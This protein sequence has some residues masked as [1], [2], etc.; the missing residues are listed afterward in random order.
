MELDPHLHTSQNKYEQT[1][2]GQVQRYIDETLAAALDE[3]RTPDGRPAITIKRRSKKACLFINASNGAL[4]SDE[5]ETRITYT[6]PGT[7]AQEAWKFTIVFRILAA[8]ADAIDTGLIVSRR[9]IYYSDPAC[10][11]TQRVVDTIVDD[12]AYTIAV[13]R[14]ALNVEAAAKGLVAGYYRLLS[15]S[16]EVMNAQIPVKDSL[17]PSL[18]YISD[19]DISDANWVLI[20]EKE[21]V[22]R[23]LARSD[24]HT[25]AAAGKGILITGK[26][27]P[28]LSTRAFVRKIFENRH[29]SGGNLPFFALVDSDPD[30]MALMST[31]KYGSVAHI[32]ENGRLNVPCLWWL[33]LRTSDVVAGAA[34][35]DDEALMR[36]TARDRKKIIA[37]LS[38]NPVWAAVGPELEWRAELQQMLMLN[39]KAELEILYD[40]EEGLEGWI[41][42][43]MASFSHEQAN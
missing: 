18:Q 6:W 10:F 38:N 1:S 31:Y 21:A 36:L 13:D 42:Q 39:L 11:G 2:K 35:N 27:Y 17:I 26:G 12:L 40:R 25:R 24:Y 29:Q 9:D 8:I 43:K 41:D 5:T 34:C 37:M 4:E 30:G 15:R 3:L 7:N 20:V 28:D 14:S 22:Y 19:I 33:G 23:R 32:G 16:G